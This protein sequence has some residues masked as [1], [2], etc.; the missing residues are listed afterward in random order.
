LPIRGTMPKCSGY[1]LAN[2]PGPEQGRLSDVF[3]PF[4][5]EEFL[6]IGARKGI[7]GSRM[8]VVSDGGIP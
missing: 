5:R 1:L 8:I 7:A 2:G 3:L 4:S 6:T